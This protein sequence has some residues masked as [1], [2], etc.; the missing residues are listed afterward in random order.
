VSDTFT[1]I[2]KNTDIDSEVPIVSL[3]L[4]SLILRRF[5]FSVIAIESDTF[6]KLLSSNLSNSVIVAVS[7]TVMPSGL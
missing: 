1:L 7:L 2:S 5:V 4:I 3:T 6:I